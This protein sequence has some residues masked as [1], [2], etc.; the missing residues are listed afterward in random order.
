MMATKVNITN[1]TNVGRIAL[2][3]PANALVSVVDSWG[4]G[5]LA[6]GGGGQAMGVELDA[7]VGYKIL[8]VA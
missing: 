8:W 6:L 3:Q 2:K 1:I 7:R 4:L 5:M